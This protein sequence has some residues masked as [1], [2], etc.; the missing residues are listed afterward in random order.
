MNVYVCTDH[1][2]HWAVPVASVVVAH[3]EAE[4][5]GLLRAELKKRGLGG[6]D[7]NLQLVACDKPHAVILSDGDY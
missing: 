6:A 4:A 2:G 1:A 5:A 7:F 3:D